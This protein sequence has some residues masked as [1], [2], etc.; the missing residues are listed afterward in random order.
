[1]AGGYCQPAQ[2]YLSVSNQRQG[3]FLEVL[4]VMAY[5]KRLNHRRLVHLTEALAR[6]L[7]IAAVSDQLVGAVQ[8]SV[9]H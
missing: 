5:L 8:K 6:V 7:E 4:G 2:G 9:E 3:E 1:M